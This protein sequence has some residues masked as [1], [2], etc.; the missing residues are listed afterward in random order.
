MDLVLTQMIAHALMRGLYS[1][2][3][4]LKVARKADQIISNVTKYEEVVEI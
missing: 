1:S 3:K 2:G 4:L